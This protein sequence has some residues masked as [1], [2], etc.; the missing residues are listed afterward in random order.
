[1]PQAF[2]PVAEILDSH[3]HGNDKNDFAK[4]GFEI[5]VMNGEH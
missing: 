1:M 5:L 3:F 2:P 4:N